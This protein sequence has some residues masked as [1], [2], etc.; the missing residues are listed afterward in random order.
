MKWCPSLLPFH[1][2]QMV[3]GFDVPCACDDAYVVLLAVQLAVILLP[4]D[5]KAQ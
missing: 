1:K 2:V 4:I 3:I 5:G